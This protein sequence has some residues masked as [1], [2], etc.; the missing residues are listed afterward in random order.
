M[1]PSDC[2]EGD[3]ISVELSQLAKEHEARAA[4]YENI[5]QMLETPTTSAEMVPEEHDAVAII[6]AKAGCSTVVNSTAEGLQSL[7]QKTRDG[8]MSAETAESDNIVHS[9]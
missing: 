5:A 4:A 8:M 6:N 1:C 7:L 2:A 9:S 3:A